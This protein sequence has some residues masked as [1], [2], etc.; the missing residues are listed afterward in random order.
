MIFYASQRQDVGETDGV[1][2]QVSPDDNNKQFATIRET[3]LEIQ[4]ELN[5]VDAKTDKLQ[6]RKKKQEV[7]TDKQQ[8]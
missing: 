7:E 3:L 5:E 4:Q 2:S 1:K 6:K 8:T